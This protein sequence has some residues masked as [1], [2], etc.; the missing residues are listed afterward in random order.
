MYPY[1]GWHVCPGP[2]SRNEYMI[3]KPQSLEHVA[4]CN[5]CWEADTEQIWEH[6]EILIC[7]L[8]QGVDNIRQRGFQL[9]QPLCRFGCPRKFSNVWRLPSDRSSACLVM[10]TLLTVS[11]EGTDFVLKGLFLS[12]AFMFPVSWKPASYSVLWGTCL[13]LKF[14]AL[15]G[16]FQK[17]LHNPSMVTVSVKDSPKVWT[18]FSVVPRY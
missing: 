5:L 8:Y 10:S 11:T 4:E 3:F 13:A 6:L 16:V 15:S 2:E 1:L 7:W 18:P 14:N 9:P 17:V 12:A